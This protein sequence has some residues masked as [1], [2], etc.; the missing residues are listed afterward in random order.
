[1]AKPLTTSN[2]QMMG[3]T[4]SST[5]TLESQPEREIKSDWHGLCAS[6][7]SGNQPQTR[8]SSEDSTGRPLP[9]NCFLLHDLFSKD[10]C[11]ALINAAETSAGF[12][13]TNYPKRYRGNLRLITTDPMLAAVVWERL[14]PFV[15]TRVT[16]DDGSE[17]E[18][19]GLNECWR[20]AKYHPGDVFGRHY[21]A[22]FER[23]ASC[24]SMFTVNAY[25]NGDFEGGRTRFFTSMNG[26]DEDA[27]AAVKGDAGMCL[28]FQQPPGDLLA[29][30]GEKVFAGKKYLF[31]S[32]VM[33]TKISKDGAS[34]T[35]CIE[36]TAAWAAGLALL[37]RAEELEREGKFNEAII[38]YTRL[39]RAF[40]LVAERFKI[41]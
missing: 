34:Q 23:S 41:P 27:I 38:E 18:P 37:Q 29:H 22:S 8:C 25:M 26:S 9:A 13:Y 19:T 5:T 30:D 14:R 15:P 10:E 39:K 7:E 12:G 40:P 11:A 16:L 28:L 2:N 31:R 35:E 17:W 24:C 1:M 32:D 4:A 21:D 3:Q 6:A 33:F 36:D 20:L